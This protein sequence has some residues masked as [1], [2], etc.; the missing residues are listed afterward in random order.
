LGEPL[1]AMGVEELR[2]LVH[3]V[4][5]VEAQLALPLDIGMRD[6]SASYSTS[7]DLLPLQGVIDALPDGITVAD[8]EGNTLLRN[9]AAV[10]LLGSKRSGR[11][12]YAGAEAL[13]RHL[14]GTPFEAEELP[15][16]RTLRHGAIVRGE[17]MLV[18]HSDTGEEVARRRPRSGRPVPRDREAHRA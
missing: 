5:I 10:T 9:E 7:F 11:W 1:A 13:P 3:S 12:E 15:G 14:D 17:P 6:P 16:A 4:E 2:D 18:R 8:R